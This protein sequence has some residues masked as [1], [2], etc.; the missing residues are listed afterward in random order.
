MFYNSSGWISRS[1]ESANSHKR[2]RLRSVH[3]GYSSASARFRKLICRAL[4][5]FF[6]VTSGVVL[7][8]SNYQLAVVFLNGPKVER[9]RGAFGK[10][11]QWNRDDTENQTSYVPPDAPQ[12]ARETIFTVR[13]PE[14]RWLVKTMRDSYVEMKEAG[15]LVPCR[16]D[17]DCWEK[18]SIGNLPS[19]SKVQPR[20]LIR[21]TLEEDRYWCEKRID[22]RGGIL[23]VTEAPEKCKQKA[24][25]YVYSKR[26]PTL[27]GKSTPPVELFW[28]TG[29]DSDVTSTPFPCSIPCTSNGEWGLVSTINVKNTNWII[30]FTMEGEKYYSEAHVGEASYRENRYF[31]TTSFKS[32]IPL[33]YFSF[34][35]YNITNPEVDFDKVIKGASFLANNCG[36][37][38]NR[39]EFV[40]ALMNTSLR[41]DSMS[42][43]VHNAEPP[44]GM[45]LGNKTEVMEAY[46]FHLSFENQLT[47]DY[48]TEKLWGALE[49]GTLP[50]YLGAP[51][52]KERA[53]KN[54]IIVAEDF[55][56]PRELAEYLVRLTNDKTLYESY[57]RWR[58]GPIDPVFAGTYEFTNTHS[59]CRMCKWAFAKRHG[60]G[61]NHTK[62]EIVAPFIPHR[63]CRNKAGLVGHPFKE[64]WLFAGDPETDR[65]AKVTS[66][67][68][69]KTCDLNDGNRV[70][71]IDGGAVSRTIFDQDGVTDLV[72]VATKEAGN[73]ALR[74]ESPIAATKLYETHDGSRNMIRW[75]QDSQSRMTILV[76]DNSTVSVPKPG[77]LM[78]KISSERT[79]IRVIVED[80]DHFHMG[81]RKYLN[82][83]GNLMSRDFFSPIE[84]YR[85][86]S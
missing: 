48:V 36:T 50:V 51:N 1:T 5:L 13:T 25:S 71:D 21:N 47:E 35:E 41:V 77:T 59:T 63:T 11:Y 24:V 43:C 70:L 4:P 38:S 60:L 9:K 55:E 29:E 73:Y 28:N 26:P 17:E 10:K 31:A 86:L 61:W 3:R 56:S 16:L 75:W 2:I 82:Y 58:H 62:Q 79:R 78:I 18:L 19:G 66:P 20:I 80:V 33:P 53:P 8:F 68:S 65:P 67:D 54:S 83:F 52:I 6:V 69:T 34:A 22:G 57:H 30:I 44:P 76:S 37:F 14:E 39:D 81:A 32:E 72:V 74:L 23:D 64:Y 49:S 27:S 7:F 85:V 15:K 40:T 42:G 46:L 12:Q 84:A 45:N